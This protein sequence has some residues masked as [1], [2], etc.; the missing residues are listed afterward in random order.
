[1]FLLEQ[2]ALN[3]KAGKAFAIINNRNVEVFGLKKFQSEAEFQKADFPVVGTNVTQE[4]IKGVKMTGSATVYYGTPIFLDML[5]EYLK[6]GKL[7]SFV[8]QITNDDKGT[9]V[10]KQVV[11]LYNVK[12][13]KVPIALLDDSADYLTAEI[14]FSYTGIE[15]LTAFNEKP[16]QLGGE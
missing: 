14:S 12:L 5:R 7:P 11:V 3:G 1:M 13:N 9:T 15:V 10:G 16:L 6:T 2:D 8:F 4:K